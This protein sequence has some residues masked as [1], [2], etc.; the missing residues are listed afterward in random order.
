MRV[1]W[2]YAAGAGLVL[3]APSALGTGRGRPQAARQPISRGRYEVTVWVVLPTIVRNPKRDEFEQETQ[4]WN[5]L[6]GIEKV[7]GIQSDADLLSSLREANPKFR[8]DRVEAVRNRTIPGDMEWAV[9]GMPKG[10]RLTLSVHDKDR[11][12]VIKRIAPDGSSSDVKGV[13]E[14]LK[15]MILCE[16]RRTAPPVGQG[17]PAD[18][19]EKMAGPV[20]TFHGF[21][22]VEPGSVVMIDGARQFEGTNGMP[23]YMP[24]YLVLY[25]VKPVAK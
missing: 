2:I 14:V 25:R 6:N 3:A 12:N 5:L 13:R 8:F 23:K 4:K 19:A 7:S 18:P 24:T 9:T 1:M 16:C 21:H 15:K 20:S 11:E 10:C 22:A 17:G